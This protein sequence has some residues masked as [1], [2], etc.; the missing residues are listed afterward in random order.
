MFN[1]DK[2][3]KS[4]TCD[5]SVVM[6]HVCLLLQQAKLLKFRFYIETGLGFSL[7]LLKKKMI[8]L[9]VPTF[10]SAGDIGLYTEHWHY[11]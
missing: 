8:V 10:F 4:R 5:V 3:S 11:I 2:T 9:I 1:K 7:K 6:C